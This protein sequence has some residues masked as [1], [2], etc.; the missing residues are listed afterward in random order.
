MRTPLPPSRKQAR[1]EGEA[2]RTDL[3][4]ELTK[5][6]ATVARERTNAAATTT[7]LTEERDALK[8]EGESLAAKLSVAE[9]RARIVEEKMNSMRDRNDKDVA[10]LRQLQTA[11]GAE[12]AQLE[13]VPCI[14]RF[15][16]CA[17]AGPAA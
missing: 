8:T 14:A 13:Q 3:K 6:R 7:L 11:Q 5:A 12:M 10:K 15:V 17:L 1:A 4:H 16:P 9:D 2:E